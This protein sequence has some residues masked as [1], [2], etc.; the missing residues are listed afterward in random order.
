LLAP[1]DGN[2]RA[3]NNSWYRDA[4]GNQA[5]ESEVGLRGWA[6]ESHGRD[7]KAPIESWYRDIVGDQANSRRSGYGF[8]YG[9]A[10]DGTSGLLLVEVPGRGR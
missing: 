6:M 1:E 10:T 4:V 9:V 8:G 5:E 3:P 2:S 7:F